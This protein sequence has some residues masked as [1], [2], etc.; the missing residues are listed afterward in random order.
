MKGAPVA[1]A[2]RARTREEV[3][4]LRQEGRVPCLAVLELGERQDN[5]AYLRGICR[6]AEEDGLI[7]RHILL[8]EEANQTEVL[9]AVRELNQDDSVHGIL[10]MRPL[11]GDLNEQALCDEIAP[12]K[13]VDGAGARSLAGVFG[14][15]SGS[16]SP[17]TAQAVMEIL[18]YYGVDPEGLDCVLVGRS[19]VVGRPLAMLLLKEN[20]TV[21][22]CHS[23]TKNLPEITKNASLVVAALGKACALGKEHFTRDQILVDVGI[24]ATEAGLKGDIDFEAAEPSC[25]AITPVPGGVG[26]VTTA[27]LLSHVAE[28]AARR[29]DQHPH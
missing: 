28:S 22:L 29:R 6:Q 4:A 15:F 21:T 19:L 18:H 2:I 14:G 1:G 8:L 13:D 16:F 20:A 23:R 11:P 24:H 5:A 17:C 9:A 26:A 3:S 12:E 25:R 10:L 7:V 27:V